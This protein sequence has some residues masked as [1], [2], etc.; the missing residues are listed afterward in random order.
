MGIIVRD[1]HTHQITFYLKGADMVMK[2]IVQYNDWMDEE[3]S[4]G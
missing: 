1:E 3:V 4:L 2:Y